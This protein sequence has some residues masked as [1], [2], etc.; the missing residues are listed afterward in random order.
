MQ[1]RLR[2]LGVWV[3]A[4]GLGRPLAALE[5]FVAPTGDDRGAGTAQAPL[6]TLGAARDRVRAALAAGGADDVVVRVAAGDYFLDTPLV[7]DDRDGGRDGHTVTWQGAPKLATRI[8]G[9]RRLTGWTR[10]NDHEFAAQVPDLA[11]HFTLYENDEEANGGIFHTFAG[12]V[13]GNWSKRG[14]TLVYAPRRQP[15]EQQVIVLGTTPDVFIVQGRSMSQPVEQLV[16]DGLHMIGSDFAPGWRQGATGNTTWNGDYDGRPWN[17][18]LLGDGVLAPDMRHGQFYLEN[19]RR[20]TLRGCKL[21]GAGFMAAMFNHWAQENRVENC[22]IDGAGCNGLFFLGWECGRGPFKTVAESYVNRRN[23]VR[24]NVF[25][26][27]GRFAGDGSGIYLTFSGDNLVEHNVFRGLTRYGVATKGWR[28]KMMNILYHWVMLSPAE[29]QTDPKKEFDDPH[30]KYYDGYVVTEENQ[31]AA[32]SH[33]RNNRIRYNDLAQIAR[34]GSDMGML[35]MWGAGTGNVWEYNA[36]HDG[37]QAGGWEE[38]MHCLFNDDGS[39]QATLR[40]NILYWLAGGGR[41]RAIMSKGN[42]QTNVFNIL[43]DSDLSA[44]A[45]IGPY[46]EAAHDMVWSRNVVAAQLG[47]L[48]EGGGGTE[49]VAGVPHP[50]LKEASA[51][52]YWYQPLGDDPPV[53]A[54]AEHFKRQVE[55]RRGAKLDGDSLYADPK[56][57]RTHPW[58][59]ARY[60]DYR[61]QPD[62]PALA[63][64]FQQTDLDQIGLRPDYPFPLTE[65]LDHPAGR[66]WKAADFSRLYKVRI[67]GEQVQTRNGR[68]PL[69]KGSWARYNNVDFGDGRYTR[70]RART[71]WLAPRQTFE[72][73]RGGQTLPALELRDAWCPLAYWDV[74]PVYTQ[75]GKTGPELF[76]VAFAPEQDGQ[77]VQWGTVSEPQVSRATVKLP[78]GVVSCDLAHGEGH[79]NS[80]G[81]LRAC[82][83]FRGAGP[84]ELEIRG[85]HG[86]KVWLNGTQVFAQLGNVNTSKR[87]RINKRKGWN[88]FLVKIVQDDR[89]WAPDPRG[90]GNFWASVT[91]YYPGDGTFTLPGLPGKEVFIQPHPGTALEL[92]LDAPQG[93]VVG[94]LKFG[95]TDCPV[96]PTTGRH[97]L[98]V[99]FPNE[100]ARALDWFRF[101]EGPRP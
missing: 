38:W 7:L 57:A 101:E 85:A 90:Y 75:P 46:V 81:Y 16:F 96:V 8:Y 14:T 27:I 10:L 11:Q 89:P 70:F 77:E 78:R 23:V 65:V 73:T 2:V 22:W 86:V 84:G 87:V 37:V 91:T 3:L 63:L 94:E 43:A 12:L 35:E 20:I 60:T 97:D 36:C 64:G 74:S 13:E 68:D 50:F 44:A 21:Y 30:V 71:E 93:P 56:F 49:K 41:S 1:R 99:V 59:D 82:V 19:A 54:A 42:E 79:A 61:L 18:R 48:Y 47:A 39:H 25:H 100:N 67:A 76:D 6:A 55:G 24:N 34:A 80:A 53:A 5:V 33:S 51:N 9:G 45:T 15:I 58:W 40:G 31:G 98:F 66:T 52:L 69:Y 92:R 32:L 26:D 29:Q 4:V 72:T 83:Y 28:P 88:Q 17:G 95:Q 62:S